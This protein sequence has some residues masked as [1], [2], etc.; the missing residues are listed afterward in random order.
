M[1]N[2]I[3]RILF[4][5]DDALF[6]SELTHHLQERDMHVEWVK[7]YSQL[8]NPSRNFS[9]YDLLLL[10]LVLEDDGS[11]TNGL[12]TIT[13]VK[14]K[15]PSLPIL[16]LTSHSSIYSATEAFKRGASDF[17]EKPIQF[18]KDFCDFKLIPVLL[19][20]IENSAGQDWGNII[21]IIESMKEDE[22]IDKLIL[23]LLRAMGFTNVRKVGHHGPGEFGRDIL[24][25]FKYD[26]F[27]QKMFYAVQVKKGNITARNINAIMDQAK[28]A[29]SVSF[30]DPYD[31]KRKRIDKAIIIFSGKLTPD[32][33]RILEDN[34]EI[35]TNIVFIDNNRLFELLRQNNLMQ[36]IKSIDSHR[37]IVLIPA[38]LRARTKLEKSYKKK[39]ILEELVPRICNF[40]GIFPELALRSFL[41][42]E[43]LGST[44]CGKYTAF[45]HIKA[46]GLQSHFILIANS[47]IPIV[48]DSAHDSTVHLIWMSLFRADGSP[49]DKI[50]IH[51]VNI[52]VFKELIDKYEKYGGRERQ[53]LK[54]VM[55]L[56]ST[57]LSQRGF[58]VKKERCINVDF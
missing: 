2:R 13:I 26:E 8:L 3:Y 51:A 47:K 38:V 22:L 16:I 10:D 46:L 53:F 29:L 34:L 58:K 4:A 20:T 9:N 28:T 5:E 35:Q 44:Y 50:Q 1:N 11:V 45:P 12:E 54:M 42:R 17:I 27:M 6:G 57:T 25:F 37:K 30:I 39:F 56:Q 14:R 21:S 23:P 41:E 7:S 33:S 19:H 18:S 31:N 15:M 49:I 32:A 48:W 40:G 52:N 55:E 24:P 43:E 36:L